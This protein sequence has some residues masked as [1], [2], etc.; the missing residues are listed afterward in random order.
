MYFLI[1]KQRKMDI[2]QTSE[3]ILSIINNDKTSTVIST[4]R[5][6]VTLISCG[7]SSREPS[8]SPR[9]HQSSVLHSTEGTLHTNFTHLVY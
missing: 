2:N 8:P 1:A 5:I 4:P 9:L 7:S 3:I 6:H